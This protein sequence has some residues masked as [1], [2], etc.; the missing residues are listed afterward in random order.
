VVKRGNLHTHKIMP[1]CLTVLARLMR[2]YTQQR[3]GMVKFTTW[4]YC[5]AVAL[6][7]GRDNF[8][9]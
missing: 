2:F 7:D 8:L 1:W 5:N 4:H 6:Q 9:R 3:E